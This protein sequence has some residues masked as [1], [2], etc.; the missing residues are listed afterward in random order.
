[1]KLQVLFS[2]MFIYSI[3]LIH[4]LKI[5]KK[6]INKNIQIQL[7]GFYLLKINFRLKRSN[8]FGKKNKSPHQQIKKIATINKY[9][10]NQKDS[11]YLIYMYLSAIYL[12]SK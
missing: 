5:Q 1:M 8:A 12:D 4:T 11:F 7:L 10:L 2:K 3:M 6:S 9:I